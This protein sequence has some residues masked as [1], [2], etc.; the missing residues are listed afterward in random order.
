MLRNARERSLPVY[1]E[2]PRDMVDAPVAP[3]PVLPRRAADPEALGECADEIV[4]KLAAASSPV[5]MVD[6]EIRRYGLEAQGRD[7]RARTWAFPWSRHSWAAVCWRNAPGVVCGT[8]LGSA[9]DPAVTQLVEEADALLLL[10]VIV[11]DTNFALSQKS[12][13]WRHTVLA[14]RSHGPGR[15]SRLSRSADRRPG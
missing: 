8:Y 14:D 10:G 3:V 2:L 7:A 1:I 6:V 5:L 13:D 12:F 11:C 9:G 15:P 4:A